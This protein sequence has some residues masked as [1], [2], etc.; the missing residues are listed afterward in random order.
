MPIRRRKVIRVLN[1][2]AAPIRGIDNIRRDMPQ[3]LAI[4]NQ[5]NK[6][7]NEKNKDYKKFILDKFHKNPLIKFYAEGGNIDYIS[8]DTCMDYY[9]I[10]ESLFNYVQKHHKLC[11]IEIDASGLTKE[12]FAAALNVATCFD[13]VDIMYARSKKADIYTPERYGKGDERSGPK[14][15]IPVT[16]V[17][18]SNL[19]KKDSRH[20]RVF[21]AVFS[22]HLHEVE[23]KRQPDQPIVFT[24]NLV[25][26]Y[27]RDEEK[28]KKE[29]E[30]IPATST[31]QHLRKFSSDG[32]IR[33]DVL[34][35]R[36][37]EL[38]MTPFG[39]GLAR[40]LSLEGGI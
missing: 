29:L 6:D 22:V 5:A 35:A 33:M 23:R 38:E 25:K 4:F 16:R 11:D 37:Y 40:A 12:A 21:R 19:D 1:I 13:N 9:C 17:Q 18:I 10:F 20:Y 31:T 15:I 8:V 2:G 26:D 7:W 30:S 24:S 14:V 3:R 36:A 34:S 27:I 39:I 28:K 32:L